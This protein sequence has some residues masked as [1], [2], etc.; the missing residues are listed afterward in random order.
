MKEYDSQMTVLVIGALGLIG[1]RV[2]DEFRLRGEEVV[3]IDSQME[4]LWNKG[5]RAR[6]EKLRHESVHR[7]AKSVHLFDPAKDPDRLLKILQTTRFS[8]VVNIGGNSLASEFRSRENLLD[9]S[10]ST[11]N[12]VCAVFCERLGIRYVYVS[13]SMIYGDFY[14]SPQEEALDKAFPV[15]PYGALKLGC[16]HLVRAVGFQNAQFDYVI[17]RPSAVYGHLDTNE[18]V[19]V[20]FLHQLDRGEKVVVRDENEFLDFTHVDDLSH[21]IVQAS[22]HGEV[23]R[24]SFNATNGQA[25]SMGRVLVE[26]EKFF[27]VKRA[28]QHHES[29]DIERPRRGTLAMSKFDS[30]FGSHRSRGIDSGIRELVRKSAEDG[31]LSEGKHDSA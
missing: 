7:A 26:F 8:S 19:L 17:L 27:S 1:S 22:T 6:A 23:I 13:S 5:W 4:P 12:R 11:L 29:E 21:M 18:R 15:D 24:D 2:V 10:M 25:V 16:E 28:T 31:L 30:V 3:A 14:A 20:K 9:E